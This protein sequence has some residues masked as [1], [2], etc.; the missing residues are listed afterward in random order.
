MNPSTMYKSFKL[1]SYILIEFLQRMSSM[2]LV[3]IKSRDMIEI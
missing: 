2:C 3:K 1:K